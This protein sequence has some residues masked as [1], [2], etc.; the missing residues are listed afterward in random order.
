MNIK[1]SASLDNIPVS[2]IERIEIVK[3]AASTLYGGE[4]M[5]GCEHHPEKTLG[6]QDWRYTFGYDGQLF[7]KDRGQLYRTPGLF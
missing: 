1:D 7:A 5:G 4:A 3:G 6:G 2:M